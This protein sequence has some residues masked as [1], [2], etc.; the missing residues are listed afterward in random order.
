M[1]GNEMD[2]QE[3]HETGNQES[4]RKKAAALRIGRTANTARTE[5][6]AQVARGANGAR[7]NVGSCLGITG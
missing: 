1:A 2:S 5:S 7:S 6:I 4:H 3:E